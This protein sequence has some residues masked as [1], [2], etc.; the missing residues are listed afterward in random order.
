MSGNNSSAKSSSGTVR[1]AAT[2][3]AGAATGK[4]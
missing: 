1:T 2:A 3:T 4:L